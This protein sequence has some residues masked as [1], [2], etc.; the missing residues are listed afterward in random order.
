MSPTTWQQRL[1]GAV[2]GHGKFRSN[3]ETWICSMDQRR[4]RVCYVKYWTILSI[5]E[6]IMPPSHL[7]CLRDLPAVFV[8]RQA[9]MWMKTLEFIVFTPLIV[10]NLHS[11]KSKSR[12]IGRF[13]YIHTI[14]HEV[15]MNH[16]TNK[17]TWSNQ[18]IPSRKTSKTVDSYGHGFFQTCEMV[19]TSRWTMMM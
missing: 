18:C 8:P 13:Q 15:M 10:R 19:A 7:S 16:L 12:T 9:K 17:K 6:P 3:K 11:L 5:I 1:G 2:G 4:Q 14:T